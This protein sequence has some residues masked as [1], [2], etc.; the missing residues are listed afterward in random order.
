MR[1]TIPVTIEKLGTSRDNKKTSPIEHPTKKGGLA[2]TQSEKLERDETYDFQT[3]NRY[4]E[5]EE[6]GKKTRTTL[7][8]C[9][10]ITHETS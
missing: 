8:Q 6:R 1:I 7:R 3:G 5:L 2:Q 9:P 4:R 10:L